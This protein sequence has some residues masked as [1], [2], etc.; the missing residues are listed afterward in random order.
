MRQVGSP[1]C[2]GVDGASRLHLANH[3]LRNFLERQLAA[4]NVR[5][6]TAISQQFA[7]IEHE[8]IFLSNNFFAEKITI[9][10]QCAV[11]VGVDR[12]RLCG[13]WAEPR[14]H[15]IHPGI[16]IIILN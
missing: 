7:T 15:E 10:N 4:R 14:R 13:I 11:E 2:C 12:E 8:F 6:P 16:R 1:H 5:L 3:Q 9:K